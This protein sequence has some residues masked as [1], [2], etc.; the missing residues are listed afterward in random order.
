L[1]FAPIEPTQSIF[2]AID[3]EKRDTGDHGR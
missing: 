2:F 3:P 1:S